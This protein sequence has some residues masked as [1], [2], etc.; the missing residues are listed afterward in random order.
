VLAHG[1]HTSANAGLNAAT[2]L[3]LERG[4]GK[5]QPQVLARGHQPNTLPS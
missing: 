2:V 1:H 5:A 3:R 4:F